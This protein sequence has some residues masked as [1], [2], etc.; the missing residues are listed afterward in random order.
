MDRLI[1]RLPRPQPRRLTLTDRLTTAGLVALAYLALASRGF[2]GWRW[3]R[4][5]LWLALAGVGVWAL[6][7]A[8]ALFLARPYS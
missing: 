1:K 2:V 8:A 4:I 3:Q 7:I 6:Y 5:A